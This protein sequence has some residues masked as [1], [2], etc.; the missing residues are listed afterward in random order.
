MVD[1]SICESLLET[2]YHD[3]KYDIEQIQDL[4]DD[5]NQ[6]LTIVVEQ[7]MSTDQ[8]FFFDTV[9]HEN[10]VQIFML[11]GL[12]GTGKSFLQKALNLHFQLKEKVVLCLAPTNFI[13]FQQ[14]GR[15]IHS[16]I[17]ETCMDLNISKFRVDEGIITKLINDGCTRIDEMS[18]TDL[19]NKITDL[20]RYSNDFVGVVNKQ[21]SQSMIIL[22]D[23]GTMV[24]ATLFSLLYYTFPN[25]QFIIMYGPNQLPPVISKNIKIPSCEVIIKR[26]SKEKT[27][28]Y[29]LESQMRFKGNDQYFVEFVK[30]FSDILSGTIENE[31][32]N[33]RLTK[34]EK[35]LKHLK[36]GGSLEDYIKLKDS[37]KI[38]IVTTNKQRCNENYNRLLQEG[39]GKIYNIPTIMDEK[40]PKNY[41][42]ESRIGIDRILSLK[43]GLYCI[44][45]VNELTK[46]LIKGQVVKILDIIT[47]SKKEKVSH[48]KVLMLDNNTEMFMYKS[49]IP[50]DIL[51]VKNDEN[52][53]LMVK[54]FPI[55]LSYALTA[56]SAQG[57]TLDSNIGIDIQQFDEKTHINSYFVAITRVRKANQLFMKTHPVYWLY[58]SMMIKSIDDVNKI[59]KALSIEDENN[60]DVINNFE[61]KNYFGIDN[62]KN[63]DAITKKICQKIS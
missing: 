17:K 54:Q 53:A 34:I 21:T 23:E 61:I 28:F 36:I 42:L 9:T 43:K 38:L 50:T 15:T 35:F 10:N 12:P 11:S 60:D 52:T 5:P 22:I 14:K 37:R 1:P 59:R 18:L 55:T 24:S 19:Y 57:K 47:D 3:K 20:A 26:E 33:E 25:A 40:I 45:R 2:L 30:Y 58:P 48:L 16:A 51:R 32:I 56:H 46:G 39:E 44:V 62:L 27:F 41:D 7:M 13:A 4:Q 63:L 49:E 29:H 31:N 6:L 8:R